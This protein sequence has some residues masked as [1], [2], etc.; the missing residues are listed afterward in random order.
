MGRL[1][2]GF[3]LSLVGIVMQYDWG[4][5]AR[6]RLGFGLV[7]G[8]SEQ[9]RTVAVISIRNTIYVKYECCTESL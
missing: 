5:E 1:V 4:S 6:F 2:E 3:K 7:R 8:V 9:P